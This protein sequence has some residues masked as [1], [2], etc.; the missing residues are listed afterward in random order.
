MPEQHQTCSFLESDGVNYVP[1][2][3]NP[4]EVPQCRPI[5]DFFKVLASHFY[6]KNW[7]AKATEAL[8]K[9][10]R[11]NCTSECTSCEE[12]ASSGVQAGALKSLPLM[13]MCSKLF[14]DHMFVSFLMSKCQNYAY[15]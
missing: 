1:N 7:L 14:R 4:T 8:K 6:R 11:R 5:E 13:V 15:L 12:E 2:D 10:I 9:R 3:L